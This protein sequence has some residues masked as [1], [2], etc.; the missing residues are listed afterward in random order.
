VRRAVCAVAAGVV[1]VRSGLSLAASGDILTMGITGTFVSLDPAYTVGGTPGYD[2]NWAIIPS[3]VRYDYDA[4][5]ALTYAKTAY[6]E[7]F[8]VRDATH[9]DFTLTKGLLWSGGNGEFTTR[10]VQYSFDRMKL[11]TYK[12][13]YDAYDHL[14]IKD[15]YNATIVLKHAFAPFIVSTLCE[16]VGTIVCEKAVEAVGGRFTTKMP[17]LCGPYLYEWKQ[18]QYI[19]LTPNPEWTGP[20][21]AF[22]HINLIFI[23][24][25]LA[26]A[27]AYEAGEIDCTKIGPATYERYLKKPP[28]HSTLTVAGSLQAMWLGINQDHPK[29]KDI[30]VR[31]AIQ[32]AIDAEA[33]NLGAYG[34]A[35]E[36]AFG[37]VP[38]GL[39]GKRNAS[40][41]S[42]NPSKARALLAQA[43]V[44]GLELTLRT[45]NQSERVLAATIIQA[46]LQAVG[47]KASV[48]PLDV[49]PY[50]EMGHE[51][52]GDLWKDLE[53]WISNW[54][55][56]ADPFDGM[57]WFVREQVGIWNWERWTDD[58]Y[59]AL[60]VEGNL[61]TDTARR[62]E[63]Y[64]RMQEIMEDTG[65]YVWLIHE[66]EVYVHRDNLVIRLAPTGETQMAY[67]K[68]A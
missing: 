37:L 48:L 52:Q 25:P 51:A 32:H 46:N 27:L 30:R 29:L 28:P 4:D 47:I 16:G 1:G 26:S 35:A 44:S 60:F 33:V 34:G 11:G 12:G 58:E 13:N 36:Q 24:E 22:A 23:T 20:K 62:N 6:V 42:Y 63:I 10:D 65:C 18:K 45:L 55:V 64:L 19:K 56:G 68:P 59:D 50:W 54:G 8:T 17:A 15:K 41:Y 7:S 67:F 39:V 61:S 5:G 14:D 43:G 40:K 21:P 9:I 2:I 66:S 38:P 3:L 49:G 31:Q 53:L 57:Q